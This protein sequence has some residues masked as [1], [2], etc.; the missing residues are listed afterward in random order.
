MTRP[1]AGVPSIRGTS[2]STSSVPS[3]TSTTTF[4]ISGPPG[5]KGSSLTSRAPGTSSAE[6]SGERSVGPTQVRGDVAGHP[7]PVGERDGD[8]RDHHPV[9]QPDDEVG[10][11][12]ALGAELV[13]TGEAGVEGDAAGPGGPQLGLV[14]AAEV[15]LRPSSRPG[16]PSGPRSTPTGSLLGAGV[17]AG[18]AASVAGRPGTSTTAATSTAAAPAQAVASRARVRRRRRRPTSARTRPTG[19]PGTSAPSAARARAARRSSSVVLIAAPPRRARRAA[20]RAPWTSG[21]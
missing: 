10:A 1:G 21:S 5:P 9:P 4:E 7:D 8:Q 2:D 20:A 13:Q 12:Q 18:G 17:D 3:P 11:Q 19:S 14:E 16:K 6:A 15:R